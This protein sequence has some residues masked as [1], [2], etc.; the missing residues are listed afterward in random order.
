MNLEKIKEK[1]LED[2]PKIG[3]LRPEMEKFEKQFNFW[4]SDPIKKELSTDMDSLDILLYA[5]AVGFF[6][7]QENQEK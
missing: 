5:Y 4:F 2:L 3:L 7:D 1:I 6:F